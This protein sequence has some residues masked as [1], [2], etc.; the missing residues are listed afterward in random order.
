MQ[1]P[2]QRASFPQGLSEEA[3]KE[4]LQ[5]P[6]IWVESQDLQESRCQEV[7]RE[8]GIATAKQNSWQHPPLLQSQAVCAS[9]QVALLSPFI[10]REVLRSGKG[11]SQADPVV[12]PK[13]VCVA[14]ALVTALERSLTMLHPDAGLYLANTY[15]AGQSRCAESPAGLLPF[16]PRSRQIRQGRKAIFSQESLSIRG[17]KY[18]SACSQTVSCHV[19][20]S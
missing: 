2:Q 20:T 8:V 7:E 5:L 15:C 4:A 17:S 1:I 3:L 9:M 14:Q 16:P 10:Q 12:L 18:V 6:C 13:Q 11:L 19:T